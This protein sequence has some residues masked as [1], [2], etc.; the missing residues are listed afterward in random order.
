MI[1]HD[2]GSILVLMPE[3]EDEADWVSDHVSTAGYQ[4]GLPQ[5]VIVEPR[6]FDDLAAGLLD[7]GF[8]L[9]KG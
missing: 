6:Y 8:E 2:A 4:P 1:V 3:N 5:R 9:T 7:A